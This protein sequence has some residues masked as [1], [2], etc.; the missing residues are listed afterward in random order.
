MRFFTNLKEHNN[1]QYGVN[2][3]NDSKIIIWLVEY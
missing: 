2:I 3:N 1:E